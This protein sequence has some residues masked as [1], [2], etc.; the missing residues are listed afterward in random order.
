MAMVYRASGSSPCRSVGAQ[1]AM[2]WWGKRRGEVGGSVLVLP[3]NG[4]SA[5]WLEPRREGRGG[6]QIGEED[7]PGGGLGS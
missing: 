5:W 3:D 6:A 2:A 1:E 7:T 4:D